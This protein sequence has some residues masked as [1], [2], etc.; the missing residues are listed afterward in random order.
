[1]LEQAAKGLELTKTELAT[2]RSSLWWQ[3]VDLGENDDSPARGLIEGESGCYG[4]MVT[5]RNSPGHQFI[6]R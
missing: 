2:V 3:K 5:W 1:M 6:G 4:F